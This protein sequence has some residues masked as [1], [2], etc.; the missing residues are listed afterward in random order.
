M[1][2]D[3]WQKPTRCEGWTVA[4]V[5]LHLAQTDEMATASVQGRYRESI[6]SLAA[7]LPP[8]SDVD[9]AV[10]LMVAR[11]RGAPAA[12]LRARWQ[13]A[14]DDLDA[15]LA[16]TDPHLRVDWVT[17]QLSARSLATTRFSENWI[18]TGD[19]AEGLGLDLPPSERLHH[20]AR[21]AW[22]TLPYAFAR[23]GRELAGP[24]AFALRAPSGNAWDFMPDEPA[25]T[26]ITG[27]GAELCLVAARRLAPADTTLQAD[28]PDG[29]AV[30]EL[31]RTY[32]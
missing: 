4:D 25:S 27:D 29:A 3:G 15:A 19:V 10:D 2:D 20:I 24:V 11:E 26:T 13:A 30:L 5:V 18:H 28:G 16:V 1:G 7:G 17:G 12:A 21:L 14:A 22:R 23:S 31:V 9:G 6:G 8:T 32:A